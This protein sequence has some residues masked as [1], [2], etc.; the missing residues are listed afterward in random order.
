[1]ELRNTLDLLRDWRV[2]ENDSL[3]QVKL[4]MLCAVQ[5]LTHFCD[6]PLFYS[7]VLENGS[8]LAHYDDV[9]NGFEQIGKK[10]VNRGLD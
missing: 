5:K 8:I 1:M 7:D 2:E 3:E 6:K 9:V 4:N 10:S